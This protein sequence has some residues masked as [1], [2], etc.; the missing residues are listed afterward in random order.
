MILLLLYEC[1]LSS[2]DNQWWWGHSTLLAVKKKTFKFF[3]LSS[4]RDAKT[5]AANP[6]AH[7]GVQGATWWKFNYLT[8][9]NSNAN[10]ANKR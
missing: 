9:C 2:V 7:A 8:F 4:H 1:S 5:L 3:A 6:Y 10:I